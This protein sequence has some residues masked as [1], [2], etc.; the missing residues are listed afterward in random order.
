[1]SITNED[2][3]AGFEDM[4]SKTKT[5]AESIGKKSSKHLMLSRKRVEYL[6]AKSKVGKTYAKYGQL[7][8]LKESGQAVDEEELGILYSEITAYRERL[9]AL[10]DE[11]SAAREELENEAVYFG[12]DLVEA[13]RDVTEAFKKQAGEVVKNAKEVFKCPPSKTDSEE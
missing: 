4:F 10:E 8:Y 6:D 3:K 12:K 5:A 13:S 9:Q 2:I 11:L 1:M 7:M